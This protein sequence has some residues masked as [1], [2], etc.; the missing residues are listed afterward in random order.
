MYTST[1]TLTI[2]LLSIGAINQMVTAQYNTCTGED[3][4][5]D[6]QDCALFGPHFTEP[7][8][9]AVGLKEEFRK[10]VCARDRSKNL[11]KVCCLPKANSVRR[12]GL[13]LLDLA[14]CGVYSD[15][16]I[17]FGQDAKLFQYPWMALLRSRTGGFFCGGTLINE[18]YVL[19]AAH[20][21]RDNDVA[22][23]RLGEYD[24][25]STIDCD[26]HGECAAS[27]QD[28]PVERIIS[29]DMYSGRYKVN[30]IGL[31]RLARKASLNDMVQPICL[32]VTPGLRTDQTIYFVAGWGQTHNAVS[33]EK[34]QYTK[35]ELMPNDECTR[36]WQQSVRHIKIVDS[37]MC[38]IG[39][40]LADNCSGDSGGPLK[41][42]SVANSRFVQYGVVSFGL[43][44]CGKQSA[45]GVYTRVESYIDWILNHL[46]E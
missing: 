7:A 19:T 16:K 2:T 24:L 45:P 10:R 26:K 37:Q 36:R 8:K 4:C 5:V 21:L 12:R 3:T 44:T 30:D 1:V 9:W 14:H 6:I 39:T 28:I 25:N 29:H 23:V 20:C 33:S 18:R 46:E 15:D 42:I 11:F 31:I 17:S 43:R 32:P 22:Q 27:P 35:L 34:L 13:E 38:A 40:D 41:S